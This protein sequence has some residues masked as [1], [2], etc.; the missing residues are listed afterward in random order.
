M[1]QKLPE[2]TMR[3]DFK[4]SVNVVATSEVV[5]YPGGDALSCLAELP[6]GDAV[7]EY[8]DDANAAKICRVSTFGDVEKK[9]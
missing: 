2:V 1:Q 9:S 6:V 7:D 4:L 5:L 3:P 8:L